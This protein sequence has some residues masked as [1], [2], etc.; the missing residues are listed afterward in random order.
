M[1]PKAKAIA[2][3]I[4]KDADAPFWDKAEAESYLRSEAIQ[5]IVWRAE[6]AAYWWVECGDTFVHT[7]NP[8]K[9]F[10]DWLRDATAEA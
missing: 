6:K 2:L 5:P 4:L 7:A 9:V 8:D 3:S 1:C 10:R